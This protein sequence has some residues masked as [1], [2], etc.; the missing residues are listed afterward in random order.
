MDRLVVPVTS[1]LDMKRF[2]LPL[3][4]RKPAEADT[5]GP[6][7]YHFIH[8]PK[9][10]GTSVR[11]SLKRRGDVSLGQP[12]HSR[13][14]DVVGE[15]GIDLRYFCVVRN[16]WSRTAS[17]YVFSR[18]TARGWPA[19]DPRKLYIE[20]ASFEDYVRDQKIFDIPE[21]PGRPWMGPMNSWF[22]QLEWIT[23]EDQ[24]VRCDCLRLERLEHD[25][26]KYFGEP[27]N[28]VRENRTKNHY[29]YKELYT[30]K[31]I[32]AVGEVFQRDIDHF[33]F[34]FEGPATRGFVG[35]VALLRSP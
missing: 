19:D 21:H 2:G 4:T 17:R 35:Q 20:K 27:V 6:Y 24:I 8:I 14:L 5:A 29:D 3:F 30:P 33:G 25:L 18:Q 34:T 28:V 12:F 1:E 26:E 15:L 13:Y 9:N 31:L 32:E 23:D 11:A 7:T 10:G 22:N 16:P